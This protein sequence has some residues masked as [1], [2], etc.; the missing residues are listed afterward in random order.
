MPKY[1]PRTALA[2]SPVAT[3]VK[4]VRQDTQE[5]VAIKSFDCQC[6]QK[7]NP[8]LLSI[9]RE[10]TI[11]K[12]LSKM[13]NNHH[14]IKLLDIVSSDDLGEKDAYL[15]LVFDYYSFNFGQYLDSSL[16]DQLDEQ[17]VV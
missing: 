11:L 15:F 12:Q 4:A 10:V 13:Q 6:L 2:K 3:V 14:T 8:L 16:T 7:S 1:V 9:F 17:K 5:K